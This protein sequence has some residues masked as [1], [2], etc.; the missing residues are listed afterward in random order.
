MKEGN[1]IISYMRHSDGS[2]KKRP[3]LI[4]KQM[5]KYEDYLICGISTNLSQ[6]IK[7][8]DALLLKN[9]E[10]F[11]NTGLY[12][13]SLIRLSHL[14]VIPIKD[15][16]GTIGFVLV[17]IHSKMLQRLSNYLIAKK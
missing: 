4:L 2:F 11:K 1:I 3:A 9:S 12:E 13:D 14:L 8:F 16:Y 15:I 5:P 7:D 10:L 6:E 17:E